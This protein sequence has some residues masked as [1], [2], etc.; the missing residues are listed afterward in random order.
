MTTHLVLETEVDAPPATVFDLS[1]DVGLHLRSQARWGEEA[2]G[3]DPALPL[4]L[5][6]L[7]TWRAR[8]LGL[9]WTMTSH[10]VELDRP[11]RFVDEQVSG[12]FA[13]FRHEHLFAPLRDGRRTLMRDELLLDA[14][15]GVLGDV[16]ER[17]VLDRHVRTLIRTRNEHLVREAR[18]L[19]DER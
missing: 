13:R 14:P 9:R 2:V 7:V 4:V 10:V 15:A 8:H 16:V 18:A 3:H 6:D 12:P 17:L 5:G 19:A 11:R 1:L